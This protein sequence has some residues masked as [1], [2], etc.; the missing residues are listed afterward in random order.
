MVLMKAVGSS[1]RKRK[2]S[3]R[4][5]RTR[6]RTTATQT[7]TCPIWRELVEMEEKVVTSKT[8]LRKKLGKQL[9]NWGSSPFQELCES[10]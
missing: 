7:M 5:L 10:Q 1:K 4:R 3:R 8:G 6:M 2:K 9:E